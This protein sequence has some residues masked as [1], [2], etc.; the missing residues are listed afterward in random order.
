MATQDWETIEEGIP[1]RPIVYLRYL[2]AYGR[3]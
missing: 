1:G 3:R 2:A